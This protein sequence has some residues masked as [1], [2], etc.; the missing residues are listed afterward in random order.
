[1]TVVWEV[2]REEGRCF[3]LRHS[4]HGSKQFAMVRASES[5]LHCKINDLVQEHVEGLEEPV[6]IL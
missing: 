1:M 2:G 3:G 4:A 6:D 5:C